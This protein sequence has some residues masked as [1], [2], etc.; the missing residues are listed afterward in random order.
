MESR[1]YR[2]NVGFETSVLPDPGVPVNSYDLIT[3]GFLQTYAAKRRRITGT[4]AVPISV[5]SVTPIPHGLLAAEDECLMFL[6]SNGGDV[7]LITAN[8]QIAPGTAPGQVLRLHF[9]SDVD[10]LF[11]RNGNGVVAVQG[12]RRSLAETVLVYHWDSVGLV[13]VEA[14]WNQVGNIL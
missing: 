7:D 9:T 3:Y 8:P 14:S 2:M 10:T 4:R 1:L 12:P 6:K 13:W 5:N 11:L